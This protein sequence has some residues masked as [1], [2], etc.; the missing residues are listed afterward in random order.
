[1][2]GRIQNDGVKLE[3]KIREMAI[4]GNWHDWPDGWPTES[5]SR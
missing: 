5:G 4:Q 1:M 2:G 3:T